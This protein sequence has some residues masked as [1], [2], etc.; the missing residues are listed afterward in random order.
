MLLSAFEPSKRIWIAQLSILEN[1]P[2]PNL[3][4]GFGWLTRIVR[5]IM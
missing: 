1:E 3:G 4:G 5:R 2:P